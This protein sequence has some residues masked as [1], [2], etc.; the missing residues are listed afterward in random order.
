[1]E[2]QYIDLHSNNISQWLIQ[3]FLESGNLDSHLAFIRREYKKRRDDT[4]KIL[5]RLCGKY[6]DF[7]VPEGGFYFWCKIKQS[8]TSRRLLHEATKTGVTFVPGE[9]FYTT[10]NQ[11]KEF[12]LCFTT[13]CQ[14]V[15]NEGIQR[16]A[17]A[18]AQTAGNKG[19]ENS[20]PYLPVS[21]II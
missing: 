19:E 13:H 3:H 18:I 7:N 12:R 8:G 11:D 20:S 15:L 17:K 16:L 6:L 5:R 2:K 10:P 21:P 4:A 14:T 9:A 1:M